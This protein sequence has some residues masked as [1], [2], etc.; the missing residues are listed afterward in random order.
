MISSRHHIEAEHRIP[1]GRDRII[2][3][4]ATTDR[5]L[6]GYLQF[7]RIC[8]LARQQAADILRMEGRCLPSASL[9][10]GWQ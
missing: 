9:K 8:M 2:D 7:L 3:D 4:R 6:R 1:S 10:T 5:E